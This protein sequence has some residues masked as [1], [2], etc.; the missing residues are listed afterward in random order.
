MTS[1]GLKPNETDVEWLPFFEFVRAIENGALVSRQKGRRKS[2]AVEK[3]SLLS[4]T[5]CLK[6]VVKVVRKPKSKKIK[7]NENDTPKK[8]SKR[9]RSVNSA[10]PS[11]SKRLQFSGD[12]ESDDEHRENMISSS[13]SATPRR[14]GRRAGKISKSYL[15][16]VDADTNDSENA[17]RASDEGS[18]IENE[19]IVED[20]DQTTPQASPKSNKRVLEEVNSPSSSPD[21][22]R[23]KIRL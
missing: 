19:E 14:S 15:E 8:V 10:T 5:K 6:C 12:E 9:S 11:K 16:V 21:L 1:S 13:P 2:T 3:G 17:L 22:V 23:K 20:G 4:S 7:N 18:D